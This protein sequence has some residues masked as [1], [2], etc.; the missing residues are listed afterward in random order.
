L[1]FEGKTKDPK[2]AEKIYDLSSGNHDMFIRRRKPDTL[3]VQQMKVR[4]EQN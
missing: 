3:E 1:P 4:P 2:A